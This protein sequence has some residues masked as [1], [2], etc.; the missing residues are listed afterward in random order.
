MLNEVKHPFG[1]QGQLPLKDIPRLR[2]NFAKNRD[3]I[4]SVHPEMK[5]TDMELNWTDTED[6]ALQLMER[7]PDV[8]PLTVRFT[9]LHKWVTEIPDFAGT[10][11]KSNEKILEAIQ[12][13]WHEE[14]KD[15]AS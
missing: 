14:Y 11:E 10:A 4:Y 2:I 7:H 3:T 8:D 15:A 5:G 13:A 9:D 1:F 12:M 6:I